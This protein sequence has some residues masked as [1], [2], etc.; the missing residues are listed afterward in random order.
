MSKKILCFILKILAQATLWRYKPLVI[1]VTGS[2]GKTFTKEAIYTVL[3]EKF[4]ARRNVKNYN[5]EIG[6]PLTIL[7][8]ASGGKSVWQ[9]LQI[10]LIGFFEIF[11]TKNYPKILILEMGAD[12]MG[13]I[14]YLTGFIK[15]YVGAITAIGEIPVH[16]E[17]F[18]SVNQVAREKSNLVRSLNEDGWAVLN[19]DD[20]RVRA[21]IKKTSAQIFTYGFDEQAD[22]RASNFEQRLDN[23]NEAGISFKVD[24]QGSN[25]P[26]RLK[27]IYAK[28]QVHSVLAGMAVGLIFKMNLV[29]IAEALRG[30]RPIVGRLH[31]L[32]GVKNTRIID[33]TYNSSPSSALGAL[34][35]LEKISNSRGDGEPGRKIAALGDM[36]ELGAFT[37][38][39]HRQIGARAAQVVDILLA[40]GERSIFMADQAKK[41]G[42]TNDKVLYF[43]SSEDAGREQSNLYRGHRITGGND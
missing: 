27:N 34:D 12:K 23:L 35:L 3:K 39:A 6:A 16:V 14:S 30:Y 33:D 31:L 20:E 2:V 21:M 1:G 17:F 11:Y 37:E 38:Q 10:F 19:Y 40:V 18:Q 26:V 7:G 29:E 43:A 15:C 22:L 36:L 42:L 41:S 9:W 4:N 13:D 32:R 24:Y 5:N 8:Q 28:H 25:V